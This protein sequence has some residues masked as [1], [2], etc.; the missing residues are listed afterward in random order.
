MPTG[1]IVKIIDKEQ[2]EI[3]STRIKL[4]EI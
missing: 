2:I 1:R 4:K 3:K